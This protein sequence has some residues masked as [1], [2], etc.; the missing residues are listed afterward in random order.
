MSSALL[1][2]I[3]PAA[4]IALAVGLLIGALIQKRHYAN[5]LKNA[6]HTAEGII[7]TAKKEAAT[8]KKETVLEA[9][10]ETHQ[11]R[12]QVE[13]ELKERRAEVQQSEHRVLQREEAL[14]HRD[15]VLDRKE[16]SVS[17]REANLNE[18]QQQLD[19]RE[20][21]ITTE[22]AKQQTELERIAE[23]THEEAQKQVLDTAK[24]ELTHERAS[25]IK[26]SEAEAKA[27]ADQTARSLIADAIQR[28]ASDIVAE[29]TVTVV[30]LP[31][32]DM[33]GRI[34]GREGRNIRTLETLTGIDL[35]IDDTPEAVVLSGFD[36]IRREIARIALE[37]LIQDG[38][39]HPAR[40]EEMVDKARKEMDGRIREIGEQALFDVGIHSMHPD[41]IK[42]LG[43][44]HFRTSYGQ[45]VL[46]H[47]IQ[48]AKL[49]G[50]LA[51]ELG[52]DVTLAKRAGLL[53]DIG[54]ALD[55][56]VD[57]SH[58]EIGV[59][60]SKK[61]KEP[62][63]VVNTIASHHGDVEPTSVIAVL[64]AASDAI[65]AAR[66]GARSESL[67][68]YLHRLE[69]LESIANHHPGVDHSF[70]IQAGREIRVVV[71]P[72]ALSDDES[73]ILAHDIRS[74]I[75][76]E[77]QYPGHIKVTV[78]REMRAIEYAK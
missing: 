70:A 14:D 47:S 4:I 58:V 41:L 40:I 26:E 63:V 12:G 44:L 60:I 21:D 49:A 46:D 30:N 54:K 69:K 23:L 34:I 28:S 11:Y 24:A 45:N 1:V 22:I 6:G 57:G 31:N 65:S 19:E 66:P 76:E 15:E 13:A 62:A 39:I 29:S 5:D 37:K 64:V 73:V 42:I 53:H 20:R 51:A 36:P 38:R 25:L 8:L 33:K 3:I 35:I 16:Q 10:D 74:E 78:I 59:E 9:K 43:R 32:D 55:H 67:E 71:K 27:K 56:E 77:L 72:E 17:D 75:E 61:Y 68:N 52:E 2:S 48:V 50:V 18:R 7:E